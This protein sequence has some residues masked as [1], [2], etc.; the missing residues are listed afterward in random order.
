[1]GYNPKAKRI[2]EEKKNHFELFFCNYIF[3]GKVGV[4]TLLYICWGLKQMNDY[5]GILGNQDLGYKEK[6]DAAK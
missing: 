1:M 6:I 4:L 5:V 2:E 3:G